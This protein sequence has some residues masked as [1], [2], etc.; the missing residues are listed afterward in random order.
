MVPTDVDDARAVRVWGLSAR[1]IHDA[2]WAGRG[3]KV[4][5][6][7]EELK[8]ERGAELYLL[9]EPGR[10]VWFD[11]ATLLPSFLWNGRH[12]ARLR[13]LDDE[14]Q[15]YRE[16]VVE[17]ESGRVMRVER[18]YTAQHR[19][20]RR[21]LMTTDSKCAHRWSKAASR[22]DAW[23][24]V[25][26]AREW[27]ALETQ[28]LPGG[29][30]ID[31]D[32]A[33]ERRL[34]ARLV[35]T[36]HDPM[37]SLVGIQHVGEGVYAIAGER[38]HDDA[39]LVGPAWL[40]A[41]NRPGE[42]AVVIGPH[43]YEDTEVPDVPVGP[44][45]MRDIQPG[46]GKP[47]TTG[48]TP[49]HGRLDDIL[50]RT[51]DIVV[52]S[53]VL[54]LGAPF[55]LVV[56]ILIMIEDGWPVF[57][58]QVREGQGER[59]FRC[60]K[61]RSMFRDSEAL[62]KQFASENLADGPQTFI[63]N[64]PRVTRIGR[65]IRKLQIDEFPQFWNVLIGDMSVVGPRPSPRRENQFCPAWR[66][67]RLSVRP[68]ITGLWQVRRTRREGEDFQEWIRYDMQYVQ[69]R[70]FVKDVRI[71]LATAKAMVLRAL[72]NG[73]DDGVADAKDTVGGDTNGGDAG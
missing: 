62:E 50:K 6:R 29:S 60:W 48:G 56:A 35:E 15:R 31:D 43:V 58:G 71:C 72:G 8:R 44:I 23:D 39:M 40:G 25:R 19:G 34:L 18:R 4:V 17:D 12:L 21:F 68:G 52:S 14:T 54:I 59:T 5:R 64:D 57:Y 45:P 9:L 51:F 20:A 24:G 32:P 67:M 26:Q 28:R 47:P 36:W 53:L 33:D 27:S 10:L 22:R 55:F 3:V 69:S 13:L 66:E 37:R 16:L 1:E 70:T 30:Y 63:L 42:G 46:D 61:F 73:D 41:G 49:Q 7:G 11:I 38:A 65:I 2:W